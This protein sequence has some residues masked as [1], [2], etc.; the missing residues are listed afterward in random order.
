MLTCSIRPGGPHTAARS[1]PF[2]LAIQSNNDTYDGKA[3]T[4]CHQG[5]LITFLCVSSKVVNLSSTAPFALNLAT[6]SAGILEFLSPTPPTTTAPN[7][8]STYFHMNLQYDPYT[9]VVQGWFQPQ[10]SDDTYNAKRLTFDGDGLLVM[11]APVLDD[12]LTLNWKAAVANATVNRWY[13]CD[14][15]AP[16][17]YRTTAVVW[18]LGEERPQNPTFVK[19]DVVG[20]AS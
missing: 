4:T 20:I 5:A 8:T 16:A 12:R 1:A 15:W 7:I 14:T 11:T 6:T 3:V 13:I 17:P 18:G 10:N 2:Y 9:N 19:I